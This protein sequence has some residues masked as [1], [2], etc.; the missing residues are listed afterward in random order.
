[1]SHA[2]SL[3][4]ETELPILAISLRSGFTNLS[5]FNRRFRRLKGMTPREYRWRRAEGRG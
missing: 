4:V 1:M 5:N 3:L 2:E